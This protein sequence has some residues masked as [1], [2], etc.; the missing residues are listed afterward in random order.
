[1]PILSSPI[2]LVLRCYNDDDVPTKT[3]EV[4]SDTEN[5]VLDIFSEYRNELSTTL[6]A[7]PTE[8]S[9]ASQST[10]SSNDNIECTIDSLNLKKSVSRLG[11][12]F[13]AHRTYLISA[14][15]HLPWGFHVLDATKP[16]LIFWIVHSL[17]LMGHVFEKEMKDRIISTLSYLRHPS[18]GFR[19]G[20]AQMPHLAPTYAAVC[21]LAILQDPKVFEIIDRKAT[22]ELLLSLKTSEGGWRLCHNGEVDVRGTYCALVTASLLNLL[23]EELTRGVPEFITRCQ[24]YE[25]GIAG[26]PGS[27]AHGGYTYCGL[28][29]LE[30]LNKVELVDIDSLLKW[31]VSRQLSLEGG[32]SGRTNKLVD[33]CYSFWVAGCFGI[34]EAELKRQKSDYQEPLFDREALQEYILICSQTK[35]GFRDKPGKSPDY[36]HTCYCLSGLSLAQNHITFDTSLEVPE[37]LTHL[38]PGVCYK[39]DPTKKLVLGKPKNLLK[40]INPVYNIGIACVAWVAEYWRGKE[41]DQRHE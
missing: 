36:Y 12:S 15:N 5:A 23:D 17:Y 29:A 22:K 4:Q 26:Y 25:G 40:P 34:V 24:T 6:P 13:S 35:K 38:Y 37:A 16:F 8:V 14:L 3:S 32:F 10:T 21:V 33:G 7:V 18:G 9:S 1:M 28:A 39:L 20:S 11:I 27:E 19:G 31:L 41:K 30:L 2:P